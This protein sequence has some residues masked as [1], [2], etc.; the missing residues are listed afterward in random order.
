MSDTAGDITATV[1]PGG[2]I[3]R[4]KMTVAPGK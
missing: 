3:R 2:L 1:F 4:A